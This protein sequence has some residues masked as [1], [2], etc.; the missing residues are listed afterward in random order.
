MRNPIRNAVVSIT[1]RD[2]VKCNRCGCPDLC[3]VKFKSGKSGLVQ[4]AV[5]RPLWRGESPAPEGL[6]ALKFNFHRCEEYLAVKADAERRA[7]GCHPK[8]DKPR[9][10]LVDAMRPI[11]ADCARD[12]YRQLQAGQGPLF[13]AIQ[14]LTNAMSE[15]L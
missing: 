7:N 12:N 9:D 10:I 6:F 1:K 8:A 15:V 5:Q 11:I 14:I 2:L 13:E 3:W 4:T